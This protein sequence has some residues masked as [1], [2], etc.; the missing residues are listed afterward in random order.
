[1]DNSTQK[2]SRVPNFSAS[3]RSLLLKLTN[4]LKGIIESK[5][6]DAVTWKEKLETW[7]KIEIKFNSCTTGP[8]SIKFV[9]ICDVGKC[10]LKLFIIFYLKYIF[11]CKFIFQPRTFKQ[12]KCKYEA[13]KKELKQRHAKQISY[14]KGTGGGPY[15]PPPPPE[16][17]DEKLL[18]DTIAISIQGLTSEFDSDGLAGKLFLNN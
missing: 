5:K 11:S 9:K 7:K 13:I 10:D 6:T 4:S 2:K 1:M 3:D 14:A 15:I 8:V 12:L 18:A 17:E 16:N